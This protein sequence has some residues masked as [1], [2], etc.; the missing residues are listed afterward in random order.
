MLAKKEKNLGQVLFKMDIFLCYVDITDKILNHNCRSLVKNL[1]EYMILEKHNNLSWMSSKESSKNSKVFND[2]YEAYSYSKTLDVDW[3]VIANVG[4][5]FNRQPGGGWKSLRQRGENFFTEFSENVS[6]DEILV[7]H[8]L[9]R[10]ERYYELHYQCYALN[11][12]KMKEINWPDLNHK[13]DSVLLNV[14]ERSSENHHDDYTPLWIKSSNEKKNY[15]ELRFGSNLISKI[16]ENGYTIKSFCEKV[17][18]YKFY[19]YPENK[20]NW[21]KNLTKYKLQFLPP[22]NIDFFV[23]N[24]E[25][26]F[27]IGEI[28]K[29]WHDWKTRETSRIMIPCAG[30]LIFKLIHDLKLSDDFKL[31]LYDSSKHATILTKKLLTEWNGKNYYEYVFNEKMSGDRLGATGNSEQEWKKFIEWFGGEDKWLKSF[32]ETKTKILGSTMFKQ[33]DLFNYERIEKLGLNNFFT[34]DSNSIQFLS[35]SNIFHYKPSALEYDLQTRKLLRDI[36]FEKLI[37]NKN[38]IL[39]EKPIDTVDGVNWKL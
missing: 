29:M 34:D 8:I 11:V 7:G 13:N 32:I 21:L 27:H 12:K 17:R 30:L 4:T 3:V 39:H 15:Y 1:T 14:P 31:C 28:K 33:I 16:L 23:F 37:G 36:C 35:F 18:R 20:K 38:V 19:L 2:H 5:D 26:Y 10:K 25:K 24:T 6:N 9:D 22:Q